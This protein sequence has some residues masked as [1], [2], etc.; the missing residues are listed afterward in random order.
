M[1]EYA[2]K[3]LRNLMFIG[4]SGAGKTTVAEQIYFLSGATTRIGKI[5][6]G[7]T[8]MDFDP[9]EIAKKMSLGLAIGFANW[10]DHR[11]NIL[12]APGYPDFIGDSI[13]AL[14]AVETAVIVA[15]RL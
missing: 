15:N 10:N 11:I 2:M 13:A 5:D 9:E 14:P 3:R 8:Q 6:E 7:N 1:K 4:A 12:D